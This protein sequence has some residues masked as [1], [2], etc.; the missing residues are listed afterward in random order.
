M[1]AAAGDDF[2]RP[3]VGINAA[4]LVNQDEYALTSDDG[5]N[6]RTDAASCRYVYNLGT[7]SL[8]I[9][10]Y[11]VRILVNSVVVGRVTF[12]VQ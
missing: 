6:F 3:A 1:H 5:G 9:G 8:G 7:R 12:G 10:T 4:A 11:A 2:G